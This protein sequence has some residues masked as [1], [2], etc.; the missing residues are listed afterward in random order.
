MVESD[1]N[2]VVLERKI[3]LMNGVGII[4]GTI[5]G[6]DQWI[7]KEWGWRFDWEIE[8]RLWRLK[9]V[10]EIWC[11]SLWNLRWF[12]EI[13]IEFENFHEFYKLAKHIKLNANSQELSHVSKKF[14]SNYNNVFNIHKFVTKSCS[15][16]LI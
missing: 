6:D 3:T 13:W 16:Q 8:L 1:D 5:I 4:V 9:G 7:V 14:K 2:K 12:V 10:F 15:R 11:Y